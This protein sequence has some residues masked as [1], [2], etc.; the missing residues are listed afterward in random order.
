MERK[1]FIRKMLMLG[2]E[3]GETSDNIRISM[4]VND[5]ELLTK[6]YESELKKLRVTDVS[7][8]SEQL[9]AFKTYHD[10]RTN[11]SEWIA[12]YIIDDFIKSL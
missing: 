6:K 12:Q 5:A 3:L 8:R 4:I 1:Y 2:A 11:K 10:N 9:K 7:G